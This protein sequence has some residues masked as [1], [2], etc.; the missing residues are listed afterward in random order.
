VLAARQVVIPLLAVALVVLAEV[1]AA[2]SM[3]MVG[4]V[5]LM[6]AAEALAVEAE[7]HV[8]VGVALAQ[9]VLFGPVQ[10]VHSHQPIQGIYK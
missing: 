8:E 7:T 5:A 4:S 6:V 3:L 1:L 9:S 10:P 2:E